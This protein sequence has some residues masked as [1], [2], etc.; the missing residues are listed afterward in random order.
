MGRDRLT[1]RVFAV[2]V[3]REHLILWGDALDPNSALAVTPGP[4]RRRGHPIV[5]LEGL[6]S[7]APA[8]RPTLFFTDL[9]NLVSKPRK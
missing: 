5:E 7:A 8:L 4:L 2:D 9:D 6:L 3:R 1:R